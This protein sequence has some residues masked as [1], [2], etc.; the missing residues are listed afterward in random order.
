MLQSLSTLY[1]APSCMHAQW[2]MHSVGC[3]ICTEHEDIHISMGARKKVRIP[4]DVYF[5]VQDRA[6][7][8]GNMQ[9]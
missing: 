6:V 9:A 1:N 7:G 2:Y 4:I 5:P 8:T 3:S